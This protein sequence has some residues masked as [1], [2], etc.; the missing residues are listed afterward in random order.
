MT[1]EFLRV[2]EQTRKNSL[3]EGTRKAYKYHIQEY[4]T[5]IRTVQGADPPYPITLKNFKIYLANKQLKN[6]SYNSICSSIVA[7]RNYCKT[8]DWVEPLHSTEITDFRKGLKRLLLGGINP[9][10]SDAF[11][12]D[13]VIK[14]YQNVNLENKIQREAFIHVLI[15]FYGILRIS[16]VKRLRQKNFTFSDEKL[17]IFIQKTKTDQEGVGRNVFIFNDTNIPNKIEII[18]RLYDPTNLDGYFFNNSPHQYLSTNT[19][20]R[21]L[22]YLFCVCG[23]DKEKNYTSH[24][25]RRGGAHRLALQHANIETIQHQGGWSSTTFLNYTKFNDQETSEQLRQLF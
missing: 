1:E 20:S 9:K 16:E 14:I 6:L 19:L 22:F 3:S 7:I 13:D 12:L 24:S 15:Q 18:Q 4:E 23:I 5:F 25:L 11:S 17:T 8:H 21:R 2:F 10:A